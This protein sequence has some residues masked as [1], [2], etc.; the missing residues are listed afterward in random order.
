MLDTTRLP[1]EISGGVLLTFARTGARQPEESGAAVQRSSEKGS[2]KILDLLQKTP[3]LTTRETAQ[4]LGISQCAVEKQIDKLKHDGH[5]RRV[6]PDKG[7]Y[8]QA[9]GL[10]P[11]SIRPPLRGILGSQRLFV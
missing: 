3:T 7:G 5:L 11:L 8:R 10:S 1:Q 2:E 4:Q 6:G 9:M